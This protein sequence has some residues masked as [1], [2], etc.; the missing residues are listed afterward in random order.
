MLAHDDLQNVTHLRMRRTFFWCPR[1]DSNSH[2]EGPD[3]KSGVSANSTTRA[4]FKYY[5]NLLEK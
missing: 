2:P 5:C 4:H 1:G 3:P